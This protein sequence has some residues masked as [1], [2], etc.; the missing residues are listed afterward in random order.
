[1]VETSVMGRGV[2]SVGL[3]IRNRKPIYGKSL[4][5]N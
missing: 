5:N 4:L 2:R 1:M 3:D